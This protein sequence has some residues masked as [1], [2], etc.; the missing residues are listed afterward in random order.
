MRKISQSQ[1]S[2]NNV[3]TDDHTYGDERP[4][5]VAGATITS[6]NG[7]PQ[8]DLEA[9]FAGS[10]AGPTIA[11]GARSASD[12][13][14]NATVTLTDGNCITFVGQSQFKTVLKV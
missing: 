6:W 2:I 5:R 14:A 8:I 9:L 10:G 12:Q 1:S 13:P 3:N 7:P 4:R 11:G